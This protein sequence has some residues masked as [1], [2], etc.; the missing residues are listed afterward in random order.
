LML[1][2]DAHLGPVSIARVPATVLTGKFWKVKKKVLEQSDILMQQTLSNLIQHHW[3]LILLCFA[4]I[5]FFISTFFFSFTLSSLCSCY[6][7]R[8][9][10]TISFTLF[11][12]FRSFSFLFHFKSLATVFL[13]LCSSLFKSMEMSKF[14]KPIYSIRCLC[15][16]QI[17]SRQGYGIC[18]TYLLLWK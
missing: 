8:R 14:E 18:F 16:M 3:R 2:P 11:F 17:N 6:C 5:V 15:V 9:A 12:F 1:R 10:K 7:H 13:S 4:K